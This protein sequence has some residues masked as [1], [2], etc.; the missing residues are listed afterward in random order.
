MAGKTNVLSLEDADLYTGLGG[1]VR[2][3]SEKLPAATTFLAVGQF[4]PGE[5][6]RRH[7]HE[8]PGEEFYYIVRGEGTVWLGDQ[9]IPV[10]AGDCLYVPPE[11]VHGVTNS[12]NDVLEI[13]FAVSPKDKADPVEV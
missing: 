5:G 4:P 10:R 3:F 1:P 2:I 7:Y 8:A 11:V 13:V 12:G 6:L 9:T